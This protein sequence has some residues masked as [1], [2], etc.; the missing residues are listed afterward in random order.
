MRDVPTRLNGIHPNPF[1]PSALICFSMADA[2]WVR[3]TA[4]D[5]LGRRTAVLVDNHLENGEHNVRFDAARFLSGIYFV[6]M[7]T[8]N[9]QYTAKMLLMK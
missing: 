8:R 9:Q 3:V 1:N 6:R 2:E 7:E 5:A 4:Y